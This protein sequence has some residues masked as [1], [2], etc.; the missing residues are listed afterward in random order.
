MFIAKSKYKLW[1]EGDVTIETLGGVSGSTPLAEVKL[2][3]NL[4][5]YKD[6]VT[7]KGRRLQILDHGW[8]WG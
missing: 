8:N 2:H 7:V 1:S 5:K 6:E 3:S 4:I